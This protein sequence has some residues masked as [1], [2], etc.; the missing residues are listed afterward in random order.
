V[1]WSLG[2]LG[3]FGSAGN[4][5]VGTRSDMAWARRWARGAGRALVLGSDGIEKESCGMFIV[6]RTRHMGYALKRFRPYLC[7]VCQAKVFD[8]TTLLFR[9]NIMVGDVANNHEVRINWYKTTYF[10]P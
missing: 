10:G 1:H 2:G 7:L 4:E 8:C 6:A 5:R 3:H 9:W